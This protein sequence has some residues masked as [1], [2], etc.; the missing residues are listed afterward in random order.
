M[1]RIYLFI[2]FSF[3]I[4]E[5][6]SAQITGIGYNIEAVGS[7]TSPNHIPF[8]L[9]SNKFGAIP[10]DNASMSFKGSVHKEYNSSKFR[11]FDWGAGFEGWANVGHNSTFNL[12]EG[13][14]KVRLGVFEFKAGRSKEISGLCDSSLSS[15]AFAV[16]GN[17][18]GIP[19]VEISIPEFYS[20]P[21]FGE[22]FAFKG[23]F[24]HGWIG[25]T[26]VR[27]LNGKMDSLKTFFHQ[28]SLYGRF[29]KPFWKWK[30][31]GGFNH[32]VFWGSEAEYYGEYYTLT[33]LE[34][35]LYVVTG[36]PYGTDVIPSSKI[37]NHLG[38]IDLGFEY[39]F[40]KIKF[41][42]YHQFFYDIG[43]LGHFANLRDGLSGISF[44]NRQSYG[45]RTFKWKKILAEFFYSKNQAGEL[46][47]PVTPSG[48]EN[49]YNNGNQYYDG[50]S[51]NSIGIGNP[52]I[53][54]RDWIKQGLPADPSDYFI[55]NRIIA[56]HLG[57]EAS[58]LKWNFILKTSYSMNYGTFGTSEEG[59]SLGGVYFPPVY[60]IFPETKQ[61]SSYLEVNK[62]LNSGLKLG[63]IGAFDVGDLY[64]NSFGLRLNISKSF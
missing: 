59:H 45:G 28:K 36:K 52:L 57:F 13:Y 35:Y 30:F 1:W 55:N 12:T 7:Y 63:V 48:D 14:A 54:T 43:A 15:G 3:L 19:K 21:L 17:S 51:Y 16:S 31:Y 47:S 24:V 34:C 33:D 64:Y 53:G 56:L 4:L 10:L 62:Q 11:L 6:V 44:L 40:T 9:R 26:D 49:Y 37:G 25:E 46:W 2:S 41:F 42:A 8:W 22:L 61:F 18:L 32:Q 39:D 60:G 29:G 20:I 27:L 38:S 23:N 5:G 58:V 50:W